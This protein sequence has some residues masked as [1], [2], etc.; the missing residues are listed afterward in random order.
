MVAKISHNLQTT[1]SRQFLKDC[2]L[3]CICMHGESGDFFCY[4]SDPKTAQLYVG[5]KVTVHVYTNARSYSLV[6]IPIPTF[7]ACNIEKVGIGMGTRLSGGY[8]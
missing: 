3:E 7:S 6:P 5:L 4:F 1:P 8:S 2:H